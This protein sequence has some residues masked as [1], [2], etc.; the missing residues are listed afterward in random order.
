MALGEISKKDLYD[1]WDFNTGS[2]GA[3]KTPTYTSGGDPDIS[4][5]ADAT[6]KWDPNYGYGYIPNNYN[7]GNGSMFASFKE[8]G[9]VTVKYTGDS[10]PTWTDSD[11]MSISMLLC[12]GNVGAW[13]SSSHGFYCETEFANSETGATSRFYFAF[14]PETDQKNMKFQTNM[15][16]DWSS[17]N[18]VMPLPPQDK[19]ISLVVTLSEGNLS[20]YLDGTLLLTCGQ[21][22]GQNFDFNVLNELQIGGPAPAGAEFDGLRDG[23][24]GCFVVDE[25][26]IWNKRLNTDDMAFVRDNEINTLPLPEPSS[27]L[28][29][30]A[31]VAVFALRRRS[32]V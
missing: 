1:Y 13:N 2:N 26:A 27:T 25:L 5:G 19:L 14:V 4:I 24:A 6:S 11:G 8:G 10:R 7:S 28:F 30:C 23:Q 22:T 16:G 29:S 32:R 31:G 17:I 12:N 3:W 15:P 21:S 9:D 18:M 20:M